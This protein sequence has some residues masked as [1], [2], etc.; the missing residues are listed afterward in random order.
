PV[1]PDA[2][3]TFTVEAPTTSSSTLSVM[4]KLPLASLKITTGWL[5]VHVEGDVLTGDAL[6]SLKSSTSKLVTFPAAVFCTVSVSPFPK[7]KTVSAPLTTSRFRTSVKLA[8]LNAERSMMSRLPLARDQSVIVSLPKPGPNTKVSLPRPPVRISLP[9]P[10]DI[11]S[12]PA[13]PTSTSAPDVPRIVFMG[14]PVPVTV[15]STRAWTQAGP[16]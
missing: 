14:V 12:L 4:V 15:I 2:K 11:Q 9:A 5:A 16:S 1:D 10:P 8:K 13:V 6:D 7:L 3:E